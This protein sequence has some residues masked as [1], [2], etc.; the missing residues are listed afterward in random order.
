MHTDCDASPMVH[1]P[2]RQG[3]MVS[4]VWWDGW[5]GEAVAIAGFDSGAVEIVSL[6][7]LES[8]HSL[9]VSSQQHAAVMVPL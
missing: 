2:H 4:V 7:T 3:R 8:I 1:L 9:K 6:V 5:E